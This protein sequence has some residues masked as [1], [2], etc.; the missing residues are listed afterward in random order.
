M[1][2]ILNEDVPN[3]GEEGDICDVA[4][5]YGRNYLL[6]KSLAVPHTKA[7]LVMFEHRR[8]AIEKRKQEKREAARGLKE[9]LEAEPLVI[10]RP[11][12]DTGKLF[13]SVTSA[14]VVEEFEKKGITI[15]RKRIDLPE[16]NLKMIGN[17]PARVRLYDNE[18][19]QIKIVI[20]GLDKDGNVIGL[21]EA[22]KKRE[23]QAAE[24][25]AAAEAAEESASEEAPAEDEPAEGEAVASEPAE[26]AEE[27]EEEKTEE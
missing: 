22:E 24:E 1:K 3:L 13:G 25:A 17:Y 10:Q 23:E 26:E 8:D 16:H 14:N 11:A 20:E 5:G 6:P 2:V 27:Q 12:G 19:A 4:D 15:E 21:K 9:R 7:N 18:E